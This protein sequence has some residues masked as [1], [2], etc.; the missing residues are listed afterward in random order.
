[1]RPPPTEEGRIKSLQTC[2]TITGNINTYSVQLIFPVIPASINCTISASVSNTRRHSA[3]IYILL[4]IIA[5]WTYDIISSARESSRESSIG[6]TV[7]H[8][9]LSIQPASA[10]SRIVWINCVA[11]RRASSWTRFL[12]GPMA[13]IIWFRFLDQVRPHLYGMLPGKPA[14]RGKDNIFHWVH[15]RTSVSHQARWTLC[16]FYGNSC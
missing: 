13:S 8:T 12:P 2:K 6:R 15:I 14:D 5:I 7:C 11:M 16:R 4:S 1:M 3:K 10:S 9:K